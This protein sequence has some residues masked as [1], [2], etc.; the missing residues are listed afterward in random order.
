[1]PAEVAPPEDGPPDAG[2]NATQRCSPRRL[3]RHNH[4]SDERQLPDHAEARADASAR[5]ARTERETARPT[6]APC[7]RPI[8]TTARAPNSAGDGVFRAGPEAR[9]PLIDDE[10]KLGEAAMIS[11]TRSNKQAGD[12]ASRPRRSSRI[13]NRRA[14]AR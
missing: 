11:V 14:T 2:A 13:S 5:S 9:P 7:R 1:M 3:R 10:L 8:L 12:R 4:G 6:N